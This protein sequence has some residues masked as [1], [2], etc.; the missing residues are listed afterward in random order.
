MTLSRASG[1]A[2]A[3]AVLWTAPIFG[4]D[5]GSPNAAPAGDAITAGR[6]TFQQ[7]CAACHGRDGRGN[8]PIVQFL[9]RDPADLTHIRAR[10]MG[11]FPKDTLG[12]ILLAPSRNAAPE[13]VPTQMM[14][15]GP[16]FQSMDNDRR[17]ALARVEELLTFLE[18]IQEE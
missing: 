8:G 16:I 18:S 11:V 14:I 1:C 12:S 9:L 5:A 7:F 2:I 13:G 3:V 6:S 4:A 17:R 10:N 15:W